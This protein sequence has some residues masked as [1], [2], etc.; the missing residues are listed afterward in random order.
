MYNLFNYNM[1]HHVA[2]KLYSITFARF[3]GC[4]EVPYHFVGTLS[5]R[6]KKDSLCFSASTMSL[7]TKYCCKHSSYDSQSFYPMWNCSNLPCAAIQM[8]SSS[9]KY[10]IIIL[11][12]RSLEHAPPRQNIAV[13]IISKDVQSRTCTRTHNYMKVL[14]RSTRMRTTKNSIECSVRV[15]TQR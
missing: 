7:A 1:F 8:F 13:L 14:Y 3:L 5:T 9:P 10:V 12:I 15:T 2:L 6:T 11:F 4:H